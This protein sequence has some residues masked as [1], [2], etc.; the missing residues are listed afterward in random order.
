VGSWLE[1]T[2]AFFTARHAEEDT[3]HAVAVLEQLEAMRARLA[4]LLP[5]LPDD[6]A[7][8]LHASELQLAM[9]RPAL[10][11]RRRLTAA[12][13]RRLLAG[14]SS[15]FDLHVLTPPLL[16]ARASAAQ[17][18]RQALLRTPS[19]LYARLA[20]GAASPRLPPPTRLGP[21]VR[22]WRWAWL[23]DGFGAWASGQTALARPAIALRLH[24]D[25]P[26]AFPPA[27]RDAPLL[28]GTVVDL[29]AREEGERAV[30]ALVVGLHPAGPRGALAD[31]FHGRS[32]ADSESTWR[33]HLARLTDVR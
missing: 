32:L 2:S 6:V 17:G 23:L 1:T 7:V 5:A 13:A 33:A 18:S 4:P 30:A 3:Q 11:L 16:E 25:P 20:A 12:S 10:P 15:G 28:G 22:A 27:L 31:A 9:A 26:P 29:L 8:V 21:V 24:E 19:A 14:A